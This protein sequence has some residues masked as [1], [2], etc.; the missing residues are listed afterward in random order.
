MDL[1]GWTFSVLRGQ[2]GKQVRLAVRSAAGIGQRD[3]IVKPITAARD[4][5]LRYDEWEYT[6]RLAVDSMAGGLVGYVHLRAMGSGNLTEWHRG[7]CPVFNRQGLVIDARHNRG[8]NIEDGEAFAEGFRRLGMGKVI[9]T[10]T[11]GGARSGS[12]PA[13]CWW[14]AASSPPPRRAW[15]GPEGHWLI[16][17]HGVDPDSVVDNL[18]HAAFQDRDAQL[19]AAIGHLKDLIRRDP[20]PVP[21]PPA[22]PNKASEDNRLKANGRP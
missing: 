15:C 21:R 2:A 17:G 18:P 12:A 5:D 16:E 10:R 3:V 7:F 4:A 22:Y 11:W 13:T 1:T 8:G 9:G 20:R 19:E 6:R 14:T